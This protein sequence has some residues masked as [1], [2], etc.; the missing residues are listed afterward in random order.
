MARAKK[1]K[2][3]K[4]ART[5]GGG[6]ARRAE[7]GSLILE[8]MHASRGAIPRSHYERLIDALALGAVVGRA[9]ADPARAAPVRSLEPAGKGLGGAVGRAGRVDRPGLAVRQ[10]PVTQFDEIA[11]VTDGSDLGARPHRRRR[12]GR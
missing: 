5:T 9:G 1:A 11:H 4:R 3:R 6:R 8:A 10:V 12:A 7:P 2:K